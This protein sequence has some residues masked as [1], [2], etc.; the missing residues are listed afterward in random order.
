MSDENKK[1]EIVTGDGSGLDISPVYDHLNSGKPKTSDQKPKHIVIPQVNEQ[2]NLEYRKNNVAEDEI[3]K[4]E[5]VEDENIEDA[6]NEEIAEENEE[7][8]NQDDVEKEDED[9]NYEDNENK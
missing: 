7:S 9:N 4:D 2:P 1:I 3:D 8:D 5:N 6:G